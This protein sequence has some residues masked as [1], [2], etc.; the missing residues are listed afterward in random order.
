MSGTTE[1]VNAVVPGD[2]MVGSVE[3]LGT[4]QVSVSR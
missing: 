4:I 1:G 3:H 2:V